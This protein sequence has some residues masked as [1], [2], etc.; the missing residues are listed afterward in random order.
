MTFAEFKTSLTQ[1]TPP[2]GLSKELQALWYAG[3]GRWQQSHEIAHEKNTP[4]YCWVH[5]Y[6]HRQ[7]GDQ[8]NA[9]YWY[10]RAGRKMPNVGLEQE[11]ENIVAEL[12]GD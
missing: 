1:T 7:Q 6:L 5:A 4:N 2:A 12:L 11:W 3:Q 9:N 8:G 10:Q